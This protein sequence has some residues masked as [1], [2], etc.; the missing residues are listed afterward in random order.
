MKNIN[1]LS[2]EELEEMGNK[3]Y[4]EYVKCQKMEA[5]FRKKDDKI[6][7]KIIALRGKENRE[8][9]AALREESEKIILEKV[10]PLVNRQNALS[11]ISEDITY[12]LCNFYHVEYKEKLVED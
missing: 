4:T 8:K 12:L 9:R 2:V 5:K 1:S 6:W 10:N 3:V 11:S 7:E